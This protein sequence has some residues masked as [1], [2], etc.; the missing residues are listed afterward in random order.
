MSPGRSSATSGAW[1]GPAGPVTTVAVPGVSL[2]AV[3]CYPA[4]AGAIDDRQLVAILH[5]A[6]L[7]HFSNRLDH[8]ESW[9][10]VMSLGE[11]QRIALARVLLDPPDVLCLDEA[12]SALDEDMEQQLYA[13]IV[14][15][16]HSGILLSVGHRAT[17][18]AG[19][20]MPAGSA[21]AIRAMV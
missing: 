11:Q 18:D 12:S 9:A 19:L 4:K 8:C 10:H 3:L 14:A 17:L 1:S 7:V 20:F 21:S 6:G 13:R 16:M 15:V 2:R 5:E